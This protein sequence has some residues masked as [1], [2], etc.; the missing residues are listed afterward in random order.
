LRPAFDKA[1]SVSAGNASRS[2]RQRCV[3]MVMTAD[4]SPGPDA[5]GPHYQLCHG[6]MDPAYMGGA[7]ACLSQGHCSAQ[8]GTCRIWTCWSSRAFAAQ[9]VR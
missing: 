6:R 9:A 4:C 1:G 7:R 8:A 3:V 2:E 5:I